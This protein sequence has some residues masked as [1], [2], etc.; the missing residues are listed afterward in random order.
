VPAPVRVKK[1]GCGP[2]SADTLGQRAL[3][4]EL[5]LELAGEILLREGLVLP[6]MRTRSSS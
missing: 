6:N 1:A 4:I 2:A 3:R 5:D